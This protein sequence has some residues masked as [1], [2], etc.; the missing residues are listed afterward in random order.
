VCR[1]SNVESFFHLQKWFRPCSQQTNWNEL[2]WN[3]VRELPQTCWESG[4]NSPALHCSPAAINFVTLTRVT[5]SASCNWVNLVQVSSVQFSSVQFVCCEHGF[6]R[7]WQD[8]IW[9]RLAET[10]EPTCRPTSRRRIGNEYFREKKLFVYVIC[11]SPY[12]V[13]VQASI[14]VF[15][16]VIM[17]DKIRSV[18]RLS[19]DLR[20]LSSKLAAAA[21]GAAGWDIGTDGLTDG[22]TLDHFI[23]PASHYASNVDKIW[24]CRLA[25]FGVSS[26]LSD[27]QENENSNL[28]NVWGKKSTPVA[29]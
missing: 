12:V 21:R 16:A 5:N 15:A 17:Y 3:A 25:C 26:C 13:Y 6:R 29:P 11:N 1:L 10:H 7:D 20:S 23:V 28:W 24:Q 27:L 22:R 8:S 14:V 9:N 4:I 19:P 18:S 2:N